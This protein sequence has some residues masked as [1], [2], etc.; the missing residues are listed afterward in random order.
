[1]RKGIGCSLY[2]ILIV[3]IIGLVSLWESAVCGFPSAGES[4]G[5]HSTGNPPAGSRGTEEGSAA[6]LEFSRYIN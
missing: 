4:G 1:L 3:I 6:H 2:L 5:N